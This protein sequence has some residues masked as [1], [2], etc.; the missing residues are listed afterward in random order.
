MPKH[1]DVIKFK[2]SSIPLM[3][4]KTKTLERKTIFDVKEIL[5]C[6]KNSPSLI[7]SKARKN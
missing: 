1:T 6:S 2:L 3:N 7:D 4:S 5:V